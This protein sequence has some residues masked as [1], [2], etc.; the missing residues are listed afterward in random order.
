MEMSRKS[1]TPARSQI[2]TSKNEKQ[3]KYMNLDHN[4]LLGIR[5]TVYLL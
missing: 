4:Q 3:A 2:G 5:I 1:N